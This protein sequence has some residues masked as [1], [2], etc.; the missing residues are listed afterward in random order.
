MIKV[1]DNPRMLKR[2]VLE[3]HLTTDELYKRYRACTKPNEKVRW[4]ALHLISSGVC[5][6]DAARQV[7]RTSGWITQL[8]QRYNATGRAAV[9]DRRDERRKVGRPATVQAE[10]ALELDAAL[11]LSAPDGG[12][13]TAKKIALWIEQKTNRRLHETSAWRIL[14]SLGFTLQ[15]TRPVHQQSATLEAQTEFKKN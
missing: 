13:W 4:R 10:L 11:H 3:P 8:T 12:L 1:F 9:A 15:T 5:A 6:A 14:R 7:G 2:I